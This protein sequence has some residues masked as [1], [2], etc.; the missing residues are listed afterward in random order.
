MSTKQLIII[1][2]GGHAKVVISAVNQYT[3]SPECLSVADDALQQDGKIFC[4]LTVISPVIRAL[5]AGVLFH[6]AIGE[7]PVRENFFKAG[8]SYDGLPYTVVHPYSV[9][10]PE[11]T[12]GDG[13]FVAAGVIIAPYSII[14]D[15]TIINHGAV[16][17]HDCVVGQF[18]HIAPNATL[19]GGAVLGKHV[20]IGAGANIL[21]QVKVGDY[22]KIGAGA[23]VVNN[24]PADTTFVG[25]PAKRK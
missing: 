17:D 21:P 23:V 18:S 4:G 14:G 5:E 10:A 9:V 16:V 15:G 6:V 20:L 8:L 22:S 7:N 11:A 3:N 19:G 24:V 25:I 13:V 1:G 12:I 2:A